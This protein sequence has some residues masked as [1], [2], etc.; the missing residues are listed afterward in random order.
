[1]ITGRPVFLAPFLPTSVS[2]ASTAIADLPLATLF[3]EI[4]DAVTRLPVTTPSP[5]ALVERLVDPQP[6]LFG[7]HRSVLINGGLQTEG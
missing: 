4:S 6:P 2:P 5:K 3:F 1:M 7:I